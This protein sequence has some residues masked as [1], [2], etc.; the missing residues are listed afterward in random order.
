MYLGIA[1]APK[2]E[3]PEILQIA[4]AVHDGTYSMDFAD[5]DFNTEPAVSSTDINAEST[6]SKDTDG[7]IVTNFIVKKLTAYREKHCYK[8]AG[9]GITPKVAELCPDLCSRL[10]KDLDIVTLTLDIFR[11]HGSSQ[12]EASNYVVDEQSDAVVRKALK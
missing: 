8:F 2:D 5:Y 3:D 9:A 10:W 11:Y 6:V 4:I 7:D 12:G 1:I